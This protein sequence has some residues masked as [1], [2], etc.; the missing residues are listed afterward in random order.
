MSDRD[1]A[2][3]I[4]QSLS[5]A[6]LT[7]GEIFIKRGRSRR[8]EVGPRGRIVTASREA[9]WAVRAGNER[10][11]LF[12]A[13]TGSPHPQSEWPEPDGF[14]I[15][16]PIGVPIPPWRPP[17]DLGASLAAETEAIAVLEAIE[18]GLSTELSGARLLRAVLEEGTSETE[19]HNSR[20]VEAGYQSR[21]A[22][23]FLEVAGPWPEAA[24]ASLLLAGREV[25]RLQPRAIA[26]RLANLLVLE[27]E[28]TAPAR[29]RGEML[30]GPAV[31]SRLLNGLLPLLLEPG[32][33]R[34]V[35]DLRDRQGR[36]AS[37][38]LTVVDNGRYPGG[39]LEAP[40]DGEGLPTGEAALIER[41][42]FRR[43][44]AARVSLRPTIGNMR[45]DSWRDLPGIRPSHLYIQP[46]VDQSV[47]SLL[48]TVSR[49]FYLVEPTGPGRFDFS[50]DRFHLPVCGFILRQGRARAPVAGVWL[51]GSIRSLLQG[52]QATA[53]DLVFEPLGA[54][55]GSPTLLITGLDL[56]R[57]P[58][59]PGSLG[60]GRSHP[61]R[62]TLRDD[63]SSAAGGGKAER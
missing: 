11:S 54:M 27:R 29:E 18:R 40:V 21:A 41:G 51:A 55:I 37:E 53:R 23:L 17:A 13:G 60:G 12:V 33:S 8:F 39:V 45:R 7:E 32:A 36:I 43:A 28:G 14:P 42:R 31:G 44:L 35:R 38:T 22:G 25:R 15:G 10:A 63:L 57:A 62:K 16:L 2:G 48:G 4:L 20:G 19:I 56:Y 50:E 3:G 6:G 34:W 47:G 5:G 24:S 26:R 46:S 9:G 58:S 30:I 59:P 52:I 61:R 1:L 49:G